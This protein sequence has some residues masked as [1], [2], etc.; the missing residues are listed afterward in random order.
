LS[1]LRENNKLDKNL[2]LYR[3]INSLLNSLENNSIE[4]RG[5]V[6][7][8]EDWKKKRI[9]RKIPVIGIFFSML[10]FIFLRFLPKVYVFKSFYILIGFNSNKY[11]SK[12]EILGRFIYNGFEIISFTQETGFHSFCL[13]RISVG[14]SNK[15]PTGFIISLDRLGYNGKKIKVFKIRTMHAYSEYIH[16]YMIVNHGFNSKG[17]IQNDFRITKW[18]RVLRKFWIDE[19][20]QL[21]NIIRGDLKIVGIRPVGEAYFDQLPSELKNKRLNFKPGC[22]P[23]YISLNMQ[24]SVEEVL[25][26]DEIYMNEYSK[27]KFVDF[28]YF[29]LAIYCI[30]VKRKRSS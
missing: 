16:K 26:A 8:L 23:P 4:L 15:V 20:P 29:F 22:I 30:I 21:F 17:K 10:E 1:N 5:R 12:A 6:V 14:Y 2:E 27:N 13:R 25:K 3:D 28:R 18:G 24:S 19:I 7:T 9:L 11:L